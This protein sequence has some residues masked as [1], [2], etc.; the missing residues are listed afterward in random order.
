MYE[1]KAA[2]Q[3]LKRNVI[4]A[5]RRSRFIIRT[6]ITCGFL[7]APGGPCAGHKLAVLDR[8]SVPAALSAVLSGPGIECQSAFDKNKPA[9]TE[10][11][12]HILSLSPERPAIDKTSFFPLAS[13][14]GRPPAIRSQAEINHCCLVGRV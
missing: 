10:I 9:F 11:F 6:R 13:V 12:I 4:V 8:H 14:L 1:G 5:F 2:G 3:K 7:L